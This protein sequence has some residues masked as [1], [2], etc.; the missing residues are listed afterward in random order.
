MIQDLNVGVVGCGYWGPNLVRNFMG[1]PGCRVKSVCDADTKR[2]EYVR[3]LYSGVECTSN[4]PEMLEVKDLDAIAVATPVGLHYELGMKA[5]EARKHTLIE[6]PMAS[7]SEECERMIGAARRNSLS[8]MVGHTFLYSSAV[9]MIKQIIDAGDIGDV[10]YISSRRLNLGIFRKDINVVWDLA[11]HDI[12]IILYLMDEFP[13]AVNCHGQGNVDKHVADVS[14]LNLTFPNGCCA[15]IH[16]SWLDPRKVREMTIV[17]DRRMIVYDDL[18]PIQKIKIYDERV[19]APPHY[20]TFTDFHYSYHYGDMYAPYIQQEEPLRVECRHF[21]DC[22]R[23]GSE[24][25]T[26]GASGMNL[27]GILEAANRSMAQ[28]GGRVEI[29]KQQ[30]KEEQVPHEQQ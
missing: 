7:S 11:P 18:E 14:I 28:S 19:E 3:A 22:I 6:K 23:N 8:L 27:V 9:R 5:L 2:L 17:G 20:D 26:G 15:T 12:S 1:L 13:A 21:L 25:V 10:R 4:F 30:P 24:P 29:G 16:N